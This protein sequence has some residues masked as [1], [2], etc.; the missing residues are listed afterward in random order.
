[1]IINNYSIINLL[2]LLINIIIL[3]IIIITD[4]SRP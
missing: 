3:Y 2:L 4:L 1:M